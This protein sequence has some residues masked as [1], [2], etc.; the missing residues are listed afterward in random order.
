MGSWRFQGFPE[1]AQRHDPNMATPPYMAC[2][3]PRGE[4][5]NPKP[6]LFMACTVPR[7]EGL[8]PPFLWLVPCPKVNPKGLVAGRDV[9][10]ESYL[11]AAYR[12]L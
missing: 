10:T 8:N 1:K 6:S 3:V 5:L 2:T 4:G 9:C 11:D 12:T 7:G